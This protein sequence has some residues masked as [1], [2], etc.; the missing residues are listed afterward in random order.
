MKAAV[1]KVRSKFREASAAARAFAA[2]L[3]KEH[4]HFMNGIQIHINAIKAIQEESRTRLKL[5]TECS[6]FRKT[7]ASATSSLGMFKRQYNIGWRETRLLFPGMSPYRRR[8]WR[9]STPA[10]QIN[11]KFKLRI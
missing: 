6:A 11:W 1:K 8:R 7:A 10:Q 2:A 3:K 5:T 9:G 4:E